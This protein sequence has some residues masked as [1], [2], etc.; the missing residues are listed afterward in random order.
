MSVFILWFQLFWH[1]C[2]S[3][4]PKNKLVN[5][6]M[7]ALPHRLM[8]MMMVFICLSVQCIKLSYIHLFGH[9]WQFTKLSCYIFYFILFLATKK[10]AIISFCF[11]QARSHTHTANTT[12]LINLNYLKKIISKYIC[13]DSRHLTLCLSRAIIRT[14]ISVFTY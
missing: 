13:T 1:F 2:Y 3:C 14:L 12:S 5:L 10:Y 9:W 4:A 6:L 8:M 7:D 11:T